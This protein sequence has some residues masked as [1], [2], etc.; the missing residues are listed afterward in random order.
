MVNNRRSFFKNL[1]S[2]AVTL[3]SLKLEPDDPLFRKYSKKV[4][5]RVNKK[6]DSARKKPITTGLT[7]Y[8]GP[9]TATEANHLL[10]RTQYGITPSE[11]NAALGKTMAQTVEDQFIFNFAINSPSVGPVNNYQNNVAVPPVIDTNGLLLGEN[12]TKSTFSAY[13]SDSNNI[14]GARK[15]SLKYWRWG[16]YF[17]EGNT[18]REKLTDFWAHF[19]P[20]DFDDVAANVNINSPIFCYDYFQILR[21]NC[22][23]NFRIIIEQITKSNAMLGY[24]SGQSSTRSLPNE[25]FAREL[26]ELFTIGKDNIQENNNYTESDI[27]A[28]SKIFSGWRMNNVFSATYPVQVAFNPNYHNQENKAF[29]DKFD[30][31]NINNQVGPAGANEID[32][33]FNMLFEKQAVKISEYVIERLYRFFVYYEIDDNTRINVIVPLALQ[34]RTG[35]WEILPVLKK[36]L[37]SEHFYDVINLGVMIKSPFDFIVGMVRSM[38]INTIKADGNVTDQYNCYK[39]FNN[40][41]LDMGQGSGEFPTV[42]GHKAYYQ[43]PTYY[44]NW[45]NST[46][47]QKREIFINNMIKATTQGNVK[48]QIDLVAYVK[49]FPLATQKDPNLLINECIYYLLPKDIDATFKNDVLKK[50]G[51]LNNQAT[52]SYWTDAWNAHLLAPTDTAKLKT[53]TDRLKAMFT[54]L[55]KLAEF[56]LM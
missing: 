44:Q 25:N 55:L 42:S 35:N 31:F 43:K 2:K 20:V 54:T 36:L 26:L 4:S 27:I 52:D 23:G 21:N 15:N 19:I 18:I 29:S 1:Y 46:S 8:T 12:W 48:L 39:Y 5:G 32:L 17:N 30:F 34:F 37:K 13:S 33:F 49:L 11:L 56:Q 28:A 24:L 6:L 41:G 9:F 22:T 53:V 47:I 3:T 14:S 38:Q 16:V 7:E 10:R 50:A 45:I 40:A 51:L